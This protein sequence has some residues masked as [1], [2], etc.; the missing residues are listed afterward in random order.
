MKQN[1]KHSKNKDIYYLK[2]VHLEEQF[3]CIEQS[4]SKEKQID[5]SFLFIVCIFALVVFHSFKFIIETL[6]CYNS[7][8]SKIEIT[9]NS[10]TEILIIFLL[11]ILA[12]LAIIVVTGFI[13]IKLIKAKNS[14]DTDTNLKKLKTLDNIFKLTISLK[15]RNKLNTKNK[16]SF[17]KL[18]LKSENNFE[19]NKNIKKK[20]HINTNFKFINKI[21]NS[22]FF[23][24][25]AISSIAAYVLVTT[26]G[27]Y[28]VDYCHKIAGTIIL[29]LISLWYYPKKATIP[30]RQLV[31][32]LIAVVFI[33]M[34][35]AFCI[36]N[37]PN[38]IPAVESIILLFIQVISVMSLTI[39]AAE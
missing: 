31:F 4:E 33:V 13:S 32:V 21:V 2:N 24:L 39:T 1:K 20:N 14:I 29:G 12:M 5:I 10:S 22:Y 15:S 27:I 8:F 37:N 35:Y 30:F 28:E 17:E 36:S 34:I 3:K 11:N 23:Y 25:F 18:F 7:F 19:M 26:N 16:E 6:K 38:K 9:P